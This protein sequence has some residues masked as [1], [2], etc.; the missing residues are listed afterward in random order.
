MAK[1]TLILTLPPMTIGG[2]SA[3]ARLLACELTA[4]GHDVTMAYYRVPGSKLKTDKVFGDFRCIEITCRTPWLEQNYT[5]DTRQWRDAIEMH[6]RH[7]AVGGTVLIAN[8]LA[9][10]GV[11]HFV[12]CAAD[13]AG[14]RGF[15][16]DAMPAWRRC[17]D[18]SFVA[19]ALAR[20]QDVV[21]RSDNKIYGVSRDTVKQL[22]ALSPARA[23]NIGRLPIPVDT[24]FFHPDDDK[25]DV[26]RLGF[27]GRLDDPRKNAALLFAVLAAV[28]KRGW[29][30]TLAVTG[31][32]TP[33]LLALAAQANVKDY[34]AFSGVLDRQG[35]REFYQSLSVFIITSF[36][37]GLA[38]AGLE[39]MACGAPVVSTDC[40]GP[41]DYVVDRETGYLTSFDADAMAD[42]IIRIID[43]PDLSAKM[44]K[45][46]RQLI[47]S[48]YAIAHFRPQLSQVWQETWSEAL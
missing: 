4:A 36:Q 26:L 16:R 9:C 21:L 15:R 6:D 11:R 18:A 43:E 32:P 37:E 47:S 23:D 2:V 46:A 3:K 10:A 17:I 45:S 29:D 14:D 25:V 7:I 33:A 24:D 39:A 31:E 20:Q 8:P 13:L 35:L 48:E 44:R 42:G 34:V 38:I 27:A 28:R 41:A 12:W 5:A 1:R 30:A 19:P 22:T 40:G